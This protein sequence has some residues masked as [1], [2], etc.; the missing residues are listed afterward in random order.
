MNTGGLGWAGIFRLGLVQT[1]LGSIVVLT[2]A[3]IN[4]VMVVELALAA[5]LPGALVGLH[6]G[7]QF[8]RPRFGHGSD[9]GG[10]RSPWII[11]GMAVL[12]IGGISAALATAWMETN[13]VAGI[14]LATLAFVLVGLGVAASGTTLLALLARLV[15]PKRRAA[16]ATMVWLMMIAGFA[17]TAGTAGYF[18]DPFSSARLITVTTTVC[19]LALVLTVVAIYGVERST[20]AVQPLPHRKPQPQ[21]SF[22]EA[23]AQVWAEPAAR[24][25][26][27]FVFVSML[28]YSAQDL[29]LEP[30]AGHVFGLTPGQSTQ[31]SGVH[32]SGLLV[33]M[34]LVALLGS[35]FSGR[36]FGSLRLWMIAGCTASAAALAGLAIAGISGPPWPLNASVF[37]LGFANGTFAVAAIGS[38]MAMAGRGRESREGTRMGL[39]GAAQA[40]AFG[41]GGFLGTAAVDLTRF[42][43]DSPMLAYATV[44]STQALLFLSAALLAA[45]IE[46]PDSESGGKQS[47]YPEQAIQQ[48]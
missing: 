13:L 47:A 4:R 42:L 19:L 39:W 1:A 35:G 2:T 26:T 8:M 25:F 6:Y 10:H 41:L 20:Q 34:L 22:R 7:V 36:T 40:F 23:L 17:I 3:T 28:A 18:L 24:H 32:S 9:L 16:A 15:I 5:M 46:H 30:F 14:V 48:G 12:A 43:F 38:M 11:G 27:I 29:I 45:R 44:F 31:L 33:G 21:D 37:S